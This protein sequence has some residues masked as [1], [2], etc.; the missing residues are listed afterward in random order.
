M[1]VKVVKKSTGDVQQGK[2]AVIKGGNVALYSGIM[3]DK[4]AAGA[5]AASAGSFRS[6]R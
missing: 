5:A 4:K 3:A 2:F 1:A 6:K